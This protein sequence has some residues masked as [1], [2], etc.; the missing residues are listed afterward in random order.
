MNPPRAG[1]NEELRGELGKHT[2]DLTVGLVVFLEDS[3]MVLYKVCSQSH[4]DRGELL[5][6]RTK[7]TFEV[8]SAQLFNFELPYLLCLFWNLTKQVR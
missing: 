7:S 1:S 6:P 3:I 8:S 5:R 4:C 2:N